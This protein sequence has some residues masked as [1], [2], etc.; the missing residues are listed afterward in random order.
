MRARQGGTTE[1]AK[2]WFGGWIS[3]SQPQP[4][5]PIILWAATPGLGS[6]LPAGTRGQCHLGRATS[7]DA[8]HPAAYLQ[9]LLCSGCLLADGVPHFRA[10][11][12]AKGQSF[13]PTPDHPPARGQL[14]PPAV[15]LPPPAVPQERAGQWG[16]CVCDKEGN[17]DS[18]LRIWGGPTSSC[19]LNW[20]DTELGASQHLHPL[21]W[22]EQ[23]LGFARVCRE[24]KSSQLSG[25]EDFVEINY[26]CSA[27]EEPRVWGAVE[28]GGSLPLLHKETL[29]SAIRT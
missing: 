8:P 25:R 19:W 6:S 1:Q 23:K 4:R 26:F 27:Q 15:S 5:P 10:C 13:S 29:P 3:L 9:L 28:R 21:G 7:R 22:S 16:L 2:C 20:G 12:A 14:G 11:R 24:T 18:K 17:W